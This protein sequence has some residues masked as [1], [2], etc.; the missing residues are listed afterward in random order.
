[1][2]FLHVLQLLKIDQWY[3]LIKKLDSRKQRSRIVRAKSSIKICFRR[4]LIRLLFLWY[5]HHNKRFEVKI[6]RSEC[7]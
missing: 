5:L 6:R 1:M 7:Y 3:V 2:G 4:T